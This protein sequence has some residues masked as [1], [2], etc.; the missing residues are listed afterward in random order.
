MQFIIKLSV[1]VNLMSPILS[2][3]LQ[4]TDY[5]KNWT[6]LVTTYRAYA[7]G[8]AYKDLFHLTDGIYTYCHVA[9]DCNVNIDPIMNLKKE[10]YQIMF[11]N[12]VQDYLRS[13]Y[14]QFIIVTSLPI[15]NYTIQLIPN[16]LNK[17]RQGYHI[18]IMYGIFFLW[19]PRQ[20]RGYFCYEGPARESVLN[21]NQLS[22][23]LTFQNPR[24]EITLERSEKKVLNSW[25]TKI[26]YVFLLY[27]TNCYLPI[28]FLKIVSLLIFNLPPTPPYCK[29]TSEKIVHDATTST[30]RYYEG[31]TDLTNIIIIISILAFVLVF[32]IIVC[33][34]RRHGI[35]AYFSSN[36]CRKNELEARRSLLPK[37]IINNDQMNRAYLEPLELH[38]YS[39]PGTRQ[40]K[41]YDTHGN[42]IPLETN[43]QNQSEIRYDYAYSH[44][45]SSNIQGNNSTD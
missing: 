2:G 36:W 15:N 6:V 42:R 23:Y 5:G 39:E 20:D 13:N 33:C 31:K 1:I 19:D 25:N 12:I 34:I 4:T 44:K 9:G 10:F 40:E 17:F 41:F 45:N 11:R 29:N 8:D 22:H 14:L 3:C 37:Q 32:F 27:E 16:D 7:I 26:D 43:D 21:T 38:I 28:S 18:N 30:E 24:I 35:F